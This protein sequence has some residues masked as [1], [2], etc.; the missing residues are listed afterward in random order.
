MTKYLHKMSKEELIAYIE[1]MQGCQLNKNEI[2][3][4]VRRETFTY[5]NA[6]VAT[7]IDRSKQVIVKLQKQ[8]ELFENENT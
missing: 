3:Y 5:K 6:L 2:D 4:L 8:K 1:K 7:A